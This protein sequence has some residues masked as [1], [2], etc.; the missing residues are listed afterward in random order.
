MLSFTS[1]DFGNDHTNML[2][3]KRK[4][5]KKKNIWEWSIPR[6]LVLFVV[7][8]LVVVVVV[9]EK[10]FQWKRDTSGPTPTR[11]NHHHQQS[12]HKLQYSITIPG[13]PRWTQLD[14]SA[15][16]N[17][18]SDYQ[19]YNS[20]RVVRTEYVVVGVVTEFLLGF[21]LVGVLIYAC[22]RE[23]VYSDTTSLFIVPLE[24]Y[25]LFSRLE[26]RPHLYVALRTNGIV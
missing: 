16:K 25:G 8:L 19:H 22:H 2:H 7:L 18:V 9:L 26:S 6:T 21:G 11:P 4:R 23:N 17:R 20:L 3:H 15:S 5:K 13:R 10:A 24:S 12:N 14:S 1:G